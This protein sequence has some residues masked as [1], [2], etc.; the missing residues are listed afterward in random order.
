MAEYLHGAYGRIQTAGTKVAQQSRNAIVYIGTAP[1]HTVPGGAANVNK[2]L[3]IQNF[4]EAKKYL[5]YS[6]DWAKYTLCEAMHVHLEQKGVAPLVFI[7]VL[8]PEV[9]TAAQGGTQNLTPANGRITIAAAQSIILDSVEVKTSGE[10]PVTKQKGVDYAIAYDPAKGVITIA[11]LTTGALG[12]AAL[13]ITYDLIDATAVDAEDVIGASD[14]AGLSTGIY[15]VKNVYQ[16]TGR[17]PSFLLCPGFGSLPAVHTALVQ[18]AQKINGHWDAY[19]YA[20]LPITADGSAISLSSANTWRQTNGFNKE[21]ETVFFPL[22]KGTDGKVYHLSVLAAANLQELLI[23]QDDIPY[24]TPSNT[25]CPIIQN[26][27]LGE[28]SGNVMLDD[29][30]IN[31]HLN[32]NGIA[33]AAFVGGRWALWGAHSAD[34]GP[35]AADRLNIAETNRM[36]LFYISNDFQHRRGKSV[37]KPMTLNDIKSIVAEEQARLDGLVRVGALTFGRVTILAQE[38]AA[39]D[40]VNGDHAFLF[41][42]TTTPLAKS[43]TAIVNWT[44]EGFVTFFQAP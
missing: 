16:A 15:A 39:S 3:L 5:G 7:N 10:N 11:E 14:G 44:D 19:V 35:S 29:E 32:K 33:S 27:Y 20:D 30:A 38:D 2:P 18:A 28:D 25:D 40:M 34:Y 8:D 42:V 41:D 36:M 21:H 22:A 37:D 23:Q 43:L 6:S 31:E 9:H 4:A 12:S 17:I 1:V 26:L 13:A 24:K